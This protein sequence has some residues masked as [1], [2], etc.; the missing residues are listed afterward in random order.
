MRVMMML[1]MRMIAKYDS[2][3][4][5]RHSQ[6]SCTGTSYLEAK[7]RKRLWNGFSIIEDLGSSLNGKTLGIIGMG[8]IGQATAKKVMTS[9]GMKVTFF[10]R[11][12]ISELDFEA[13]QVITLDSLLKNADV[14][15]IHAPGGALEPILTKKHIQMMK[16][17]MVQSL[18]QKLQ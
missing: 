6:I 13:T 5:R 16:M 12:T 10:N 17:Y 11:S 7:L 18:T 15:S 1:R 4:V 8:R 14:V 9:L 3:E 2:L